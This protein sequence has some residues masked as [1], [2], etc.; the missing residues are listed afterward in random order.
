MD[1]VCNVEW[2]TTTCSYNSLLLSGW[3]KVPFHIWKFGVSLEL[4]CCEWTGRGHAW[5][6]FFGMLGLLR[7]VNE[8]SRSEMGVKWGKKA[9]L[10]LL[11][12]GDGGALGV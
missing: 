4:C 5:L 11:R 2:S 7:V 1:L 8:P 6:G 9:F 12:I 3:F 10:G